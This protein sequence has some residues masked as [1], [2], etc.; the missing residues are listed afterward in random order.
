MGLFQA[1]LQILA[2]EFYQIGVLPQEIGDPLQAG[3]E[4]DTQILQLEI[5]KS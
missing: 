5:G 1:P 2:H 3:V 4:V